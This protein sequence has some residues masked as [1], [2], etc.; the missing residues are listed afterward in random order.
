[1]KFHHLLITGFFLDLPMKKILISTVVMAVVLFLW[2]GMTQMF[3]WGVPTTQNVVTSQESFPAEEIIELPPHSL[4]TPEFDTMFAGKISTLTTD[5]TFS[6]IISRPITTYD[7]GGFFIKEIL[8]QVLAALL[9]SLLLWLTLPLPFERR[10][11]LV[12]L[13]GIAGVTATYG[14]MM[15]WWGMPNAYA[16]GSGF[17][18]LMGWML[19]AY[20]SARWIIKKS[21]HEPVNV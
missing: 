13:A 19:A 17:N 6:W 3:P 10:M 2:S 1:V 11:G 9:L 20:V 8:T 7:L 21:S 5:Q 15:N 4:T 18:L 14:Q 16:L 12:A